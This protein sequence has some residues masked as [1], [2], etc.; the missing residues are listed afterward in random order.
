MERSREEVAAPVGGCRGPPVLWRTRYIS[1]E[2]TLAGGGDAISSN[3]IRR[4]T[5]PLARAGVSARL[6]RAYVPMSRGVSTGSR[7][8]FSRT[9]PCRRARL[10][11]KPSEADVV[12]QPQCQE[13]RPDTRTAKTHKGQR[14][15]GHRHQARHHPHIDE[16]VEEQQGCHP[17]A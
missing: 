4:E 5:I 12:D 8:I 6:F 2:L 16:N 14:N 11:H 10:I 9:L 3:T 17:H 13:K 15:T 1:Y 7:T